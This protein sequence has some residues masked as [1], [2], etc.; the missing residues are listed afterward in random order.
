MSDTAPHAQSHAAPPHAPP[1]PEPQTPLWLPALGV[2]L[3]VAAAVLWATR[4]APPA[5][6]VDAAASASASASAAVDAGLGPL[7]GNP[8]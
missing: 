7:P 8:R 2:V 1:P 4:P 5:P 3:F 6:P